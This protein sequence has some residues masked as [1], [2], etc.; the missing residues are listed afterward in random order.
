M[1]LSK[2]ANLGWVLTGVSALFGLVPQIVFADETPNPIST[3]Q[4]KDNQSCLRDFFSDLARK[5]LNTVSYDEARRQ[6]FTKVDVQKDE[7]GR[8]VV[9]SCYSNDVHVVNGQIPNNNDMNV[10][11]SWPQSKLK[12]E[13]DFGVT[14]SDIYHLYP[15]D[16]HL[17]SERGSNPFTEFPG[18]PNEEWKSRYTNSRFEPPVEHRGRLARSMLYM[19]IAHDMK[20]NSEEEELFRKWNSEYPVEEFEKLRA[21]RIQAVQ[22]NKNPFIENPSWAELIQDF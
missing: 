3:C 10:E 2:A 17:N 20:I 9:H 12:K 1:L 13:S 22:G 19:A 11:H 5:N 8:L 18:L 16:S 4:T 7:N 14:R 15:S 6:I 21:S